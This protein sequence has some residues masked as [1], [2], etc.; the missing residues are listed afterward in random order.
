MNA[1]TAF[2]LV[3][4]ILERVQGEVRATLES[5]LLRW[6]NRLLGRVDDLV[7]N[8]SVAR[9]GVV[10]GAGVRR[11]RLDSPAPAA[12]AHERQVGYQSHLILAA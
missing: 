11:W 3:N 9:A 4:T 10:A 6:L 8:I 1:S 12:A 7:A 2:T 5:G